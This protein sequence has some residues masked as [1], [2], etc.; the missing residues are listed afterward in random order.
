MKKTASAA[1]LILGLLITLLLVDAPS[2]KAAPEGPQVEWSKTY[3][4]YIG[5]SL[6]QTEDG[7][8]AIAG[9]NA[10]Y[11]PFSLHSPPDWSNYT[12]LLIKT[13]DGGN[14]TWKKTYEAQLGFDVFSNRVTVVQ[15]EDFGYLLSGDNWLLKLYGN[16]NVQWNT[17]FNT[18]EQCRAIQSSSGGYVLIGNTKIADA[19]DSVNSVLIKTDENGSVLWNTT[20]STGLPFRNDVVADSLGETSDK[21][22]AIAGSWDGNFWF[23]RTDADG[24]V[25]FNKIYNLT[26]SGGAAFTSLSVTTDGG[27]VLSGFDYDPTQQTAYSGWIVK[28]DAQGNSEWNYH[29]VHSSFGALFRSI[30]Q[31]ADGGY[32][33]VGNPA[34]VKLDSSGNLSWNVTSFNAYSVLASQDGGF[35]V[36]GGVGDLLSPNQEVWVAKFASE[37]A[38]PFDETSPFTTIWIVI[39]GIVAVVIG[40]GIVV[41]FKK[42][43]RASRGFVEKPY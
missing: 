31:L 18:L 25:D 29:F 19:S 21:G 4:P 17:T 23:V 14:V 1:A 27:Y 13:D 10:S 5:Y 32:V 20:F 36:A 39:A 22:F 43:K 6:I 37:S 35:L 12:A 30:A 15:T 28:T 40:A 8:F 26:S 3:G 38:I 16:G 42:R 2:S 7:G 34:L 24:N 11:K 33:A 41:C 9:Q